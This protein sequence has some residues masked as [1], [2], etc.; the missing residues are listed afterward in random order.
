[1]AVHPPHP[2]A[3]LPTTRP[4]ADDI[5][6]TAGPALTSAAVAVRVL[7][8]A[9]DQFR[10]AVAEYIGTDQTVTM[11]MSHLATAG[12]LTPHQLA[13]RIAIT[14]SSVTSLLDRLEA[15]GLAAR[16]AHPTDRRKTVITLTEHGRDTL[17]QARQWTFNAVRVFDEAQLPEVTAM[18]TTLASALTDQIEQL[19]RR[20]HGRNT[21]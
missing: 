12:S 10:S 11:A 5:P 13:N 14:P 18:L 17:D 9:S 16:S 15:A 7:A 6:E 21:A 1:M 4:A 19:H 2:P 20:A 3:G 8:Q